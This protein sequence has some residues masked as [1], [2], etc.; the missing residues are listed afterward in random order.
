MG[1][2][3]ASLPI[4]NLQPPNPNP[5]VPG[6]GRSDQSDPRLAGLRDR[7]A[8]GTVLVQL[9]AECPD[10]D[11]ENPGGLSSVPEAVVQG[12]EDQVTLHVRHGPADEPARDRI[13]RQGVADR[14]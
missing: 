3:H 14:I 6:H 8:G 10:R 13:R 11:P 5:C 7:E 9:V 2:G 4:A 12:V 1:I